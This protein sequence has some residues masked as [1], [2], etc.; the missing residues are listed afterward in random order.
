MPKP[1]VVQAFS[2]GGVIFRV[3]P[4]VATTMTVADSQGKDGASIAGDSIEIALVGSPREGTW[5]LPKGTPAANET[6]EQTAI[7]EVREETGLEPRILGELGSIEYW[8]A[9]RGVRFH[10]EVFYY[11]MEAIGG[12]V[13]QHDHEYDEARWFALPQALTHLAYVNEKAIVRQA[14]PLI[15]EYVVAYG[16]LQDKA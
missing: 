11:V 16:G 2:A 3:Q 7:R 8:F 9:R 10:K 4:G 5:I 6:V 15:L 1:R 12:D 13:A 14:E